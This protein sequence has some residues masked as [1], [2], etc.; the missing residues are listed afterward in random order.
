LS[1]YCLNRQLN[2]INGLA[3]QLRNSYLIALSRRTQAVRQQRLG[4]AVVPLPG[5]LTIRL[6]QQGNKV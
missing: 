4:Q 3:L 2:K 5:L 6:H 1:F